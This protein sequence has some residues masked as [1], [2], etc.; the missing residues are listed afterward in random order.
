MKLFFMLLVRGCGRQ[1]PL[2]ILLS[3]YIYCSFI[4]SRVEYAS[5]AWSSLTNY[6]SHLIESIEKRALRIIYPDVLSYEDVLIC[7]GLETLATRRH[8]SCTKFISRL[9]SEKDDYNPLACIIRRQE[10]LTAD[11][12][13]KY[14]IND[15]PNKVCILRFYTI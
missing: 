8:N 9:R 13:S 6:L 11:S 14:R 12:F 10:S 2:E 7:T 15:I 4:R 3:L 5:P 1:R